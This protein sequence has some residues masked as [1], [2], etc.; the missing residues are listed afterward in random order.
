MYASQTCIS[1]ALPEEVCHWFAIALIEKRPD[2]EEERFFSREISVVQLVTVD[3][4]YR[5]M[6]IGE[7]GN[8]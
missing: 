3:A 2:R 8:W 1:H 4:N 7:E 6:E 5:M